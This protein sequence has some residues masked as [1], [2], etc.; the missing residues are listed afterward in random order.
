MIADWGHQTSSTSI[1]RRWN[2]FSILPS[3]GFIVVEAAN[4]DNA[5]IPSILPG[6]GRS[7]VS[8]DRELIGIMTGSVGETAWRMFRFAPRSETC[9]AAFHG[10]HGGRPLELIIASQSRTRSA[11]VSSQATADRVRISW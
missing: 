8:E 11:S 10:R 5:A 7:V 4:L 2:P 3:A 1:I 9:D 6:H